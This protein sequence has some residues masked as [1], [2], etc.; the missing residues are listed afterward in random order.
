MGLDGYPRYVPTISSSLTM[1]YRI[2]I[3]DVKTCTL[4]NARQGVAP[5]IWPL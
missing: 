5:T 1:V 3:L 2:E 4:F